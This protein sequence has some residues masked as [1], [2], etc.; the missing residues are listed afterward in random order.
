MK[1]VLVMGGT[2]AMGTY[3]VPELI[4]L[5]YQVDV[6]SLDEKK[7]VGKNVRYYTKDCMDDSFFERFLKEKQYDGIIDFMLYKTDAFAK[8]CEYLLENTKH[9]IFLSTYRVYSSLELPIKETSPLFLDTEGEEFLKL[10]ETEYALYKACQERILQNVGRKNWTIVR[11]SITFSKFRYQLV[12]LEADLV[13][14]RTVKGK[15]LVLPKGAMNINATMTWAGDVA[16][17]FG[18]LLFN[19]KTFEEIYSICSAEHHTWREIA[20]F[21]QELIGLEYVEV[22]DETFVE[23]LGGSD[24]AKYQLYYDRFQER[25]MDNSKI[26]AVTGMRQEEFTPLKTALAMELAGLPSD[27]IWKQSEEIRQRQI[28]MDEWLKSH[29]T[30]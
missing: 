28:R 14:D 22:E 2:G 17:L 16:K 24:N 29:L 27:T 8:R 18:R 20:G 3:V 23:L 30:E 1:K 15:K 11:P 12:T 26:L 4:R 6:I 5:G 19:E 7:V 21:Y 13:I 10:K 9:Y 25:I